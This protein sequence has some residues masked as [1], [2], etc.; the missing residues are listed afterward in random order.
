MP[1]KRSQDIDSAG[2][3]DEEGDESAAAR[4][5]HL[6]RKRPGGHRRLVNFINVIGRDTLRQPLLGLPGLAH[7]RGKAVDIALQQ[8]LLH[9]EC[10]GLELMHGIERLLF[11]GRDIRGLL[12]DDLCRGA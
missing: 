2:K 11:L 7:D 9:T 6:S 5:G 4:A 10:I 12:F 1:L 3:I 8:A